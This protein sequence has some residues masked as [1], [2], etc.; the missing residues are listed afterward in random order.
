[1]SAAVESLARFV[2]KGLNRDLYGTRAG[3]IIGLYGAEELVL[4]GAIWSKRESDA[5]Y[6]AF[7]TLKAIVHT[8]SW[9]PPADP[10]P[11][12]E[13]NGYGFPE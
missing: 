6:E 5:V 8:R 4:A 9:T 3:A 11:L 10:W 13:A 12:I 1:M 7:K 2:D